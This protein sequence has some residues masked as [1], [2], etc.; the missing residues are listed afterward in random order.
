MMRK[1]PTTSG[2]REKFQWRREVVGAGLSGPGYFA[3]FFRFFFAAFRCGLGG[4]RSILR[5]TSSRLGCRF[6]DS[7]ITARFYAVAA[8]QDKEVEVT[9]QMEEAGLQVYFGFDRQWDDPA[10]LV[11]DIYHAMFRLS[12]KL[13]HESATPTQSPVLSEHE[14]HA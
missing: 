10:E 1:L 13:A 4:V 14:P 2:C 11:M 5:S 7:C 9:P 8:P 6:G 3:R 12:P